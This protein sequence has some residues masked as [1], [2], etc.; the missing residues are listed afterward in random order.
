[1]A[2]E[3]NYRQKQP[4]S[5]LASNSI[6]FAYWGSLS[7]SYSPGRS[8][9]ELLVAICCIYVMAYDSRPNKSKRKSSKEKET[10]GSSGSKTAAVSSQ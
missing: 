9:P 6:V 8:I 3:N 7:E 2:H 10:I 4:V 1:M 5:I